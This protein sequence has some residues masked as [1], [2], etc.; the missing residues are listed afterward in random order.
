MPLFRW[1]AMHRTFGGLTCSSLSFPRLFYSSS[2]FVAS[3]HTPRASTYLQLQLPSAIRER[4][5]SMLLKE[6]RPTNCSA[7]PWRSPVG[8]MSIPE[9]ANRSS[10][11]WGVPTQAQPG[12]TWDL[13]SLTLRTIS[14][15]VMCRRC[16]ISAAIDSERRSSP[17]RMIGSAFATTEWHT[18]FVSTQL[19]T[20]QP[21]VP[22]PAILAVTPLFQPSSVYPPFPRNVP[23]RPTEVQSCVAMEI[24]TW[25]SKPH[26]QV[27]KCRSPAESERIRP[28]KAP[29]AAPVLVM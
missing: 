19:L 7:T 18:G 14:C 2:F 8:S 11:V 25:T 21:F 23:P 4:F 15:L 27:Q 22:V 12:P 24:T 17:P 10:M 1:T 20:V 6:L 26:P 28:L 29:V 9:S 5:L 13:D 3:A 16:P